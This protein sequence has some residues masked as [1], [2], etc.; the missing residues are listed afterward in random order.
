MVPVTVLRGGEGLIALS[1]LSVLMIA[2]VMVVARTSPVL[3]MM[4]GWVMIALSSHVS[5]TAQTLAFATTALVTAK[6]ASLALTALVV[7]AL[8]TVP[9]MVTVFDHTVCVRW[10]GLGMTVL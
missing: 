5:T 8:T 1:V 6:L 7:P 4:V 2:L 9:V 10:V 3:V